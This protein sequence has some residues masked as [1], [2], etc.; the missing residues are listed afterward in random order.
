MFCTVLVVFL[1][2][3]ENSSGRSAHGVCAKARRIQVNSGESVDALSD[4]RRGRNNMLWRRRKKRCERGV[5]RAGI[6]R[7][8]RER[9]DGCR[10][11][12]VCRGACRNNPGRSI[13]RHLAHRCTMMRSASPA[14]YRQARHMTALDQRRKGRKAKD[15]YEQYGECAAHR[16]SHI[17]TRLWARRAN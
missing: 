1:V 10:I 9:A 16:F 5:E 14:A 4:L 13:L 2:S 7:T 15:R 6:K 17:T 3:G 8:M 11:S 12:R